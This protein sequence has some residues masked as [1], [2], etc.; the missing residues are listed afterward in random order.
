VRIA[1]EA[2]VLAPD[3]VRRHSWSLRRSCMTSLRASF[4]GAALGWA[5]RHCRHSNR[6][7]RAKQPE[8][9]AGGASA[10]LAARGCPL[11]SAETISVWTALWH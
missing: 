11:R 1:P 2:N 6:G 3:D 10:V 8:K 9:K 7:H 5:T 4:A